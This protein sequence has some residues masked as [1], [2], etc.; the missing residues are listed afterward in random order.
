VPIEVKPTRRSRRLYESDRLQLGVYLLGLRAMA[1]EGAADFGYVRYSAATFE[2]RLTS[3]LE[4]EIR[5]AV[6]AI[7]MGR[8]HRVVHRSH[9]MPAR[10]RACAVRPY[11]DEFLKS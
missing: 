5:A 7:G 3:A 1:G 4:R 2:V 10:C 11:C 6:G 9:N 8:D